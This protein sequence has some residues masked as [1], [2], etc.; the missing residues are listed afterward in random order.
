MDQRMQD[1]SECKRSILGH[2]Q[3]NYTFEGLPLKRFPAG[4]SPNT[5]ERLTERREDRADRHVIITS[6]SHNRAG[7]E[8]L[9]STF[10]IRST[11]VRIRSPGD[12]KKL[13]GVGKTRLRRWSARA[14]G[15]QK[16]IR[17]IR[18]E[19]LKDVAGWV[20]DGESA[21]NKRFHVTKF[22]GVGK[23]RLPV[24]RLRRWAAGVSEMGIGKISSEKYGSKTPV[25]HSLT[26]RAGLWTES[27]SR[28]P[29]TLR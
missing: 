11:T 24:G 27:K 18:V 5:Q 29:T 23:T 14:G 6:F 10:G 19:K 28:Y 16:I 26:A 4:S 2:L 21:I 1:T 17:G 25:G 12:I 9:T 20:A 22:H 8:E 13:H 7:I 3:K 15:R